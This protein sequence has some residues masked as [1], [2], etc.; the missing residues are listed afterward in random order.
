MEVL[1]CKKADI[2]IMKYLDGCLATD[3]AKKLNTHIKGCETCRGDFFMYDSIIKVVETA[4]I[5]EAPPN[6][7]CNVME[8]INS[9]EMAFTKKT[10]DYTDFLLAVWGTFSIL[11]GF[12]VVLSVNRQDILQYFSH[13][14]V[15]SDYA[16]TIDMLSVQAMQYLGNITAF[17]NN[18]FNA[19][20]SSIEA[21]R[22]VFLGIVAVLFVVQYF[23]YR[24][25]KVQL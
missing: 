17:V 21:V 24:K 10:M 7:E 20:Y 2:F 12:G 19:V 8:K 3:D 18:V 23:V 15:F 9:L 13:N 1:D 11:F 6:F 22:F 25:E 14:P 4:T 16:T 5:T